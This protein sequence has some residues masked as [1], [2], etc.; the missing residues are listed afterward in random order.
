M[1]YSLDTNIALYAFVDQRDPIKTRASRELI[2]ELSK[3]QSCVL[4]VQI[5]N[6]FC[7]VATRKLRHSLTAKD[8]IRSIEALSTFPVLPLTERLIRGALERTFQQQMQYFD[9]LIVETML[10]ANVD[11]LYSE[12]MQHG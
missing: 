7:S 10:E 6:E 12:D 4:S 8:L 3:T 9:S 2:E 5:F 11:I 1:L